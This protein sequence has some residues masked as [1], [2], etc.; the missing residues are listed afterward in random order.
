MN[1]LSITIEVKTIYGNTLIYP[2]DKNA[3]LFTQLIGQKTLTRR[4]LDTIKEL[5]YSI[6]QAHVNIEV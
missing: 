4:D 1:N 2:V 5:G 6:E 3:K